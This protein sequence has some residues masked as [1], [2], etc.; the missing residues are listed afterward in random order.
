MVVGYFP[1][2]ILIL[3]LKKTR[4]KKKTP[5]QTPE[6]R[7]KMVKVKGLNPKCLGPSKKVNTLQKIKNKNEKNAP[8][9]EHICPNK[10]DVF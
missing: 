4:S 3:F 2:T 9:L 7:L 1:K 10:N 8:P 5:A 6:N